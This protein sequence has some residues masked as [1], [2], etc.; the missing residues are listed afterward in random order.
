MSGLAGLAAL[1][2]RDAAS[3]FRQGGGGLVPLGFFVMTAALAPLALAADGASAGG[4]TLRA[5]APGLVWLAAALAALLSMERAYQSDFEEGGLDLLVIGPAPLVMAALI[6]GASFWLVN[7]AP[8]AMAAPV[9]SLL[10]DLPIGRGA[11]LAA[12]LAFGSACF[13]LIGSAAAALVVGVRRGGML[14]AVLAL[15]LFTPALIFGVAAARDGLAS[16]GGQLLV[17]YTLF[18]LVACP[19]AA[20]AALRINVE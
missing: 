14:I 12:S 13:S 3:A 17:G 2:R 11:A 4:E 6:K 8:V 18:C 7:C 15:P 20:A 1:F 9:V 10:F 16:A 19:I 5:L